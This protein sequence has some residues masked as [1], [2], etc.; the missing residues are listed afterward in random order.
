MNRKTVLAILTMIL[1]TVAC[2]DDD[3]STEPEDTGFHPIV[4]GTPWQAVVDGTPIPGFYEFYPSDSFMAYGPHPQFEIRAAGVYKINGV[5]LIM[6]RDASG[7]TLDYP[8][9]FE[10]LDTLTVE[11]IIS[12]DGRTMDWSWL[13]PNANDSL[14]LNFETTRPD[15]F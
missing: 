9:N 1:L 2:S 15:G 5:L 8:Q 6:T 11:C 7:V 12:G 14:I 3:K 10:P 13:A 4:A